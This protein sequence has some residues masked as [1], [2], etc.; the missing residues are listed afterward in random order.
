MIPI[1]KISKDDQKPFVGIVDEI[2]TIT[3]DE[4]YLQN[5]LDQAKVKSL[6]AEIDQ[7]VYKL[8][9]LTSEEIKLVEGKN[10]NSD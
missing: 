6:E 1:K 7:R 9:G 8:Y 10:E 2:L 4:D 5:Q 3:K